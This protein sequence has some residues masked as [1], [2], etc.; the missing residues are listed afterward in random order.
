MYFA[1]CGV[2]INFQDDRAIDEELLSHYPDSI[3]F[4]CHNGAG[5]DQIDVA[6]CAKKGSCYPRGTVTD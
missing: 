3:K 4:I 5:Y 1:V 2:K 6:A